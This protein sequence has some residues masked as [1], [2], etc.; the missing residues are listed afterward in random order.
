MFVVEPKL[1]ST[2]TIVQFKESSVLFTN[3]YYNRFGEV[4]CDGLGFECLLNAT[5][6]HGENMVKCTQKLM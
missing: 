3:R 5:K 2:N 4:T 1:F 6:Q